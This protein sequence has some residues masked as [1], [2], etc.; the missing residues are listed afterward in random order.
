MIDWEFEGKREEVSYCQG[1]VRQ[2]TMYMNLCWGDRSKKGYQWMKGYPCFNNESSHEATRWCIGYASVY[3]FYDVKIKN[4]N[5][6]V[7]NKEKEYLFT[8]NKNII[9]CE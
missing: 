3:G 2:L 1:F 5:S 4:I 7:Y 6:R 9:F 8:T